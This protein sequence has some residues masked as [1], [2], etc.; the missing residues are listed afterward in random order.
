[1]TVV[2]NAFRLSRVYAEGWMAARS[3]EPVSR[4]KLPIVNPYPDEPEH[5]R[6]QAGFNGAL[7]GKPYGVS[8]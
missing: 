6:R 4:I 5:G 2:A 1:M 8:R 3:P 7:A